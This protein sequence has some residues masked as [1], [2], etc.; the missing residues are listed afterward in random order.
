LAELDQ[1]LARVVVRSHFEAAHTMPGYPPGHPNS[2]VHGHSYVVR[3]CVE[4]PIR[5]EQ[6]YVVEF[7]DLQALLSEACARLDHQNLNEFLPAPSGEA[8]AYWF[9]NELT[10]KLKTLGLNCVWV[11]V[12]RPTI[13]LEIEVRP[14]NVS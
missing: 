13:G 1:K 12:E 7:S 8:L 4:G 10:E 2:R 14:G 5:G 9:V 11:R 6:S 3:L